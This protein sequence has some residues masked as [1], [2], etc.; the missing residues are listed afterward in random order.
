MGLIE[1]VPAMTTFDYLLIALDEELA[2]SAA[3]YIHKECRSLCGLLTASGPVSESFI[4]YVMRKYSK[5]V[6]LYNNMICST[7]Y[8]QHTI[9]IQ[10]GSI[11]DAVDIAA[12][13]LKCKPI[14]SSYRAP[15][16]SVAE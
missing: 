15:S 6:F 4:D 16:L 14:N 11:T 9:H 8:N 3:R 13:I 1:Y 2:I 7:A 10:I 5:V 12:L